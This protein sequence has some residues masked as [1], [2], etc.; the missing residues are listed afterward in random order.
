MFWRVCPSIWTKYFAY[1]FGAG[2][3]KQ[4]KN[5]DHKLANEWSQCIIVH[6]CLTFIPH[7]AKQ[8]SWW[9]PP[10][11]S[12]CCSGSK[13]LKSPALCA[14]KNISLHAPIARQD[15]ASPLHQNCSFLARHNRRRAC[16]RRRNFRQTFG[17]IAVRWLATDSSHETSRPSCAIGTC[18]ALGSR[19]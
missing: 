7:K 8:V 15:Y 17:A 9:R 11:V 16:Y 13:T 2:N 6:T 5:P 12:H 10:A 18:R 4:F 3:S 1:L 14:A 19:R